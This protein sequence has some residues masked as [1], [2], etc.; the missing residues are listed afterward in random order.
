M[1]NFVANIA[2]AATLGVALLPWIALGAAHAEPATVKISDLNL[3]RPAQVAIFNARVDRAAGKV[4]V[5]YAEPRNLDA[6]AACKHAVRAEADSKL[7]QVVAA[8]DGRMSLAS[9]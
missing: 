7:S 1:S 6:S 2:T 5:S 8:N 9:R 4:C 3:S